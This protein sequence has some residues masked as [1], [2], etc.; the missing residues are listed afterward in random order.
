MRR[1]H[2]ALAASC[3]AVVAVPLWA[4]P[5]SA[6][7]ATETASSVAYFSNA[8]VRQ[9]DAAPQPLPNLISDSQVDGVAPGNL[10]VAAEGGR[11]S[12][13]SFVFFSLSSLPPDAVIS[14][15]VM[16]VPLA[17]DDNANRRTSPKPE[18]VRA[19]APDDTGFGG[20]DGQPLN[21]APDP[22]GNGLGY[23][24]AP[25]RKCD[26]F[27]AP[28]TGG[29]EEYVFDLTALAATWT[30]ANDGVALTRTDTSDAAFQVVFTPNARLDLEYTAP[31]AEDLGATDT[32]GE[33]SVDAGS[34]TGE[35]SIG[36]FDSGSG[37]SDL[38]GGSFSGGS[39]PLTAPL[40]AGLAPET[41]T[42]APAVA[43]RPQAAVGP[44]EDLALTP[45]F[46]L[47][48]L[49]L[50]GLLGFLGLVLGDPKVP[51][52]AAV[53]PTRLTKALSAPSGSRPSLLGP[54]S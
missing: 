7:T 20:Q 2:R 12:K 27:S 9:P 17:P 18:N 36:G 34:S 31:A 53:R 44:I 19:C 52:P 54:R 26:V 29:P 38:S 28:A 15:A 43:A 30:T 4:L 14:R 50:T 11:E 41:A 35:V 16:T 49:L 23:P 10:G 48:A 45:G 3:A 51:A 47:A 46:W 32:G 22:T 8:G 40:D 13:V 33:I 39:A 37:T 21:A 42:D 24:G 1:L 25:A 5:A 6:E